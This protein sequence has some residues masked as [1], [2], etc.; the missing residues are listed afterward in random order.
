M[1]NADLGA[2]ELQPA[3]RVGKTSDG[4]LRQRVTR[5]VERRG[6]HAALGHPRQEAI[7]LLVGGQ[8]QQRHQAEPERR[9]RGADVAVPPDLGQR[10]RDLGQSE[11]VT[12]EPLR[13]TERDDAAVDQRIPAV[14]PSERRSHHVGDGLLPFVRTEIH[15][16]P[17]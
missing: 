10:R 9:E 17:P 1:W 7:L 15:P 14:V 4:P 5:L 12:A 13:D 6:E 3:G 11:P 16:N 8:V 2:R